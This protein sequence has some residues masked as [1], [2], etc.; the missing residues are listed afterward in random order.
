MALT[1]TGEQADAAG[2]GRLWDAVQR[3]RCLVIAGRGALRP[4]AVDRLSR[5][6]LRAR[7]H[8]TVDE[9]LE[10]VSDSV[11]AGMKLAVDPASREQIARRQGV[12]K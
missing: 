9:I 4:V 3:A 5:S 2:V 8:V 10:L 12:C 6:E 11:G 7:W 1:M